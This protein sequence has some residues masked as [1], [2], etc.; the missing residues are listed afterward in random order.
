MTP[1]RPRR[2]VLFLPAAN[3][4]AIE[5]AR[6]L[7][8]DAVILD[9][10]DAVAPDAKVAARAAAVEAV[11]AGGWGHREVTIRANGLDTRWGAQDIMAAVEAGVDAIVLPKVESAD[12]AARA[13]VMA[14]HVPLWVMIETPYAVLSADLIAGVDGV[15]ALVAGT[16]DLAKDLRA[17]PGADRME[18]LYSLSRIILAARAHGRIALDG[19]HVAIDDPIGLGAVCE[20]GARLGF[21]GKTLIHPSQIEMANRAFAPT[22]DELADARGMIAAHKAAAAEGKG[23]ATYKGRMVET[24]HVEEAHRL[25]AFAEAIELRRRNAG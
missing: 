11:R 14:R 9:L 17:R 4:R 6:T 15:E 23:V 24:L 21:D 19:V 20:Q 8:C 3:Q 16:S 22:D 7:D 12:A 18:L 5:K 13:A 10:E 1:I 2:S 25:I